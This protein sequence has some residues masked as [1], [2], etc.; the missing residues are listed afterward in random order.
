MELVHPKNAHGS[1]DHIRQSSLSPKNITAL[2]FFSQTARR[3]RPLRIVPSAA[4]Q[5]A[6]QKI[7]DIIAQVRDDKEL[8]DW[9]KTILITGL[10]RVE[11]M[12][13]YLKFFGHEAAIT[14][15]ILTHQKLSVI[16]V[17]L[18]SKKS[19][20]NSFQQAV[21]ALSVI[22][23]LFVLPDAAITA[24]KHY[25]ASAYNVLDV[26]VQTEHQLEQRLL[27]APE[28]FPPPKDGKVEDV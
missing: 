20:S 13:K 1:W 15:L 18:E 27:P 8:E 6:R 22:A 10:A 14:E 2:K 19:S 26:I 17:A 21:V 4:Q 9:M 7:A 28:A 23:N 5:E 12:L 25:K 16:R 24:F 3:Y 11:L